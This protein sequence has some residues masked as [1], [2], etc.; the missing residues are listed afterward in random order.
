M[1]R[2]LCLPHTL[3]QLKYDACI[4][5]LVFG[6][7][8]GLC[9]NYCEMSKRNSGYISLTWLLCPPPSLQQL[10]Y[11]GWARETRLRQ[12]NTMHLPHV[13]VIWVVL[14][15]L[16]TMHVPHV[17]VISYLGCGIYQSIWAIN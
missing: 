17:I 13:L 15:K 8:D 11:D 16:N 2:L 1:V 5:Y 12:V 7:W 6:I 14:V 4:W 3:Q 9:G 10:K